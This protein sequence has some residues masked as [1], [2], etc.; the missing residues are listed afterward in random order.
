MDESTAYDRLLALESRGIQLGLDRV[1]AALERLG[2]PQRGTPWIVVAGTN[3]KG[4]T[5]AFLA[6]ILSAAG[7]RVGL[8]TS[9]HLVSPRERIRV[10]GA[11]ISEAEFARHAAAVLEVAAGTGASNGNGNGSAGLTF[12]EALTC[13]AFRHFRDQAV[14][15]GVLEVGLGGR[16]DAVNVVTP[17]VTVIT[18]LA[19]DHGEWLGGDVLSI[20]REKAGIL[21]ER[22]PLAV[23]VEESLFRE[24][25]GPLCL[26]GHIPVLKVGRDALPEWRHGLFSYR[27]SR[28]RLQDVSLGL[29][30]RFQ[31]VN[32][33]VAVAAAEHL[34]SRGF[35]VPEDAVRAGLVNA[36]WRG[37][38]EV[39]AEVPPFVIDVA[40]NP[41]GAE[42]L[43][44]ALA[45]RFGA[46][47]RF[48]VFLAVKRDKDLVGILRQ[49]APLARRITLAG[50]ADDALASL[51]A[52][53]ADVRPELPWLEGVATP[54]DG[55]RAA[56]A[57]HAAGRA[58]LVTGSHRLVG[59]L[60][61][62]A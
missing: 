40:H 8:Y 50:T 15:V 21:R 12:F 9:P 28:F 46:A 61:G 2:A 53:P 31:A 42:A 6:S 49:L 4:S 3:G 14:Q 23:A 10:D 32:A 13:M 25:I 38:F 52:V 11:L 45:E 37:R 58:V 35:S 43:A 16:L 47:A 48:D 54:A 7:Y 27:G 34:T 17:T 24:V 56:R 1:Q 19:L 39:L 55:V 5:S 60:I 30:G 51:D 44:L 29:G 33:A 20:A 62:G 26:A 57:A 36:R 18:T 22:V 59:E 41:N